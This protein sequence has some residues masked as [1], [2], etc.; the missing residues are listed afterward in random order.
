MKLF[1][2][3]P[4]LTLLVM[5]AITLAGFVSLFRLPV[6]DL[7]SIDSPI[8]TIYATYPGANPETVLENLTTPLEK[9]LQNIPGV[10]S[11]TSNSHQGGRR[12]LPGVRLQ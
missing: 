11:L 4:I 8:I 5:L 1:I 3:R 2:Q 7:P 9:A 6:S 12:D 10:Q